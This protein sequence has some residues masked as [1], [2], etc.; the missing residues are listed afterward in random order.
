MIKYL[1]LLRTGYRYRSIAVQKL[2]FLFFTSFF[3]HIHFPDPPQKTKKDGVSYAIFYFSLFSQ[4]YQK[5]VRLK[6]PFEDF[7]E[8]PLNISFVDFNCVLLLYLIS[9][10]VTHFK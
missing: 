1:L 2:F 7:V 8:I 5:P 3:C 6:I 9:S 10:Y 4:K